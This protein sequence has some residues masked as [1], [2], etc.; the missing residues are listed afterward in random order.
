M[1]S[2]YIKPS[3]YNKIYGRM[4]Y[5]NAL[6][7][8]VCL[9]TGLRVGDVLKVMAEDIRGRTLHYIAEKT[10]KAGKKVLSHATAAELKRLSGGSGYCFKGRNDPQKHRNRTTVWKDVKQAA[11][12]A[13]VKGNLTVHSARKTYAVNLFHNK[14]IEEVEKELQHSRLDTTMI[15]AFSDLL[16]ERSGAAVPLGGVDSSELSDIVYAACKKALADFFKNSQS[17]F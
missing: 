17:T 13:G 16:S 14:G 7:L 2:D 6:C 3:V 8:R 4:Q 11:R 15:Y 1:K 10:G 5:E 12:A 9:E